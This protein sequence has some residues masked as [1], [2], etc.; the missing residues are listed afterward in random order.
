MWFSRVYRGTSLIKQSLLSRPM[1]K[2]LWWSYGVGAVSGEP[3]RGRVSGVQGTNVV[4]L[5]LDYGVSEGFVDNRAARRGVLVEFLVG[6]VNYS[7]QRLITIKDRF[8]SL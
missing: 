3:P 6:V 4:T 1:P 7:H 5:H 8:I 2:A